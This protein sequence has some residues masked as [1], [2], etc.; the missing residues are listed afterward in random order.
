MND[1]PIFGELPENDCS[2]VDKS[3]PIVEMKRHNGDIAGKLNVDVA[4]L[5]VHV[6]TLGPATMNLFENQ[7]KVTFE[8]RSAVG[9]LG[10]T[11]R[12]KYSGIVS[13]RS[14]EGLPIEIVE[15]LNEGSERFLDFCLVRRKI[16]RFR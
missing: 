8:F 13:E 6:W 10:K 1:L 4:R 14:S 16:L 7:A 11:P 15:G 3:G 5:Q 2:A 12:I 9:T